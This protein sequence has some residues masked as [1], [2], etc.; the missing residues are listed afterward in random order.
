[1]EEKMGGKGDEGVGDVVGKLEGF[2]EGKG[3]GC[4]AGVW[5]D[6]KKITNAM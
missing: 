6:V 2:L 3:E 4:F 5:E 1:M